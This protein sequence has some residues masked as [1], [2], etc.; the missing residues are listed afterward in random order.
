M[1]HDEER[2]KA[3]DLEQNSQHDGFSFFG[4]GSFDNFSGFIRLIVRSI[5]NGVEFT[6]G[7]GNGLPRG[8]YVKTPHGLRKLA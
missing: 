3:Y 8:R 7:G 1:L 2:R 4:L 5:G 6:W